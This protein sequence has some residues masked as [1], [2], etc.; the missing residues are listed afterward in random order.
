M[1]HPLLLAERFGVRDYARVYSRSQFAATFGVAAG[2]G[3]VGR[4]A[5]RPGRVRSRVHPGRA[6]LGARRRGAGRERADP[7][8]RD[9]LAA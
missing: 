4:A 2:P 1:L 5:R 7:G 6:R 3:R 8:G 9:R